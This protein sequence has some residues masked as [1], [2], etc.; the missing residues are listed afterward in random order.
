MPDRRNWFWPHSSAGS[1]FLILWLVVVFAASAFVAGPK[2]GLL[3]GAL[4]AAIWYVL[5]TV[6]RAFVL[7]CV[8]QPGRDRYPARYYAPPSAPPSPPPQAP[9][10][11]QV[12]LPS[13]PLDPHPYSIED[14]KPEPIE[15]L[16]TPPIVTPPPAAN[17]TST[18]RLD[19]ASTYPVWVWVLIIILGIA[20][21][22]TFP[23]WIG[24]SIV[25]F[26]IIGIVVLV[27]AVINNKRADP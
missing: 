10:P 9:P 12:R 2:I 21:V 18:D 7:L 27:A 17:A 13:P 26:P 16:I 24:I 8:G 20:L 1:T 5:I 14:D 19:G 6:V 25:L 4:S 15:V 3:N 23:V 22:P 11:S